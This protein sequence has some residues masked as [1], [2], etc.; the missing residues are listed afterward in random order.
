MT[1][2]PFLLTSLV[3]AL[4]ACSGPK[5]DDPNILDPSESEPILLQ[6]QT[7]AETQEYMSDIILNQALSYRY[8]YYGSMDVGFEDSGAESDGGGLWAPSFQ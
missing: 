1:K 5:D 2:A 3:L 8:S 7:C 6:F 4:S